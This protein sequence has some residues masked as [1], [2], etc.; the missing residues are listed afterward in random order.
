[1]LGHFQTATYTPAFSKSFYDTIGQL[2]ALPIEP[3][4]REICVLLSAAHF[5]SKYPAYVRAPMVKQF[6]TLTTEQTRALMAGER[7]VDLKK[8]EE[9]TFDILQELQVTRGP[10]SDE[11]F[12][13]AVHLLGKE[14]TLSVIYFAGLYSMISILANGADVGLPYGEDEV[15]V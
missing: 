1:L 11:T 4:V 6:T 15:T 10:L 13:E 8:N 2:Y 3:N 14:Q 7:P 12:N 9:I 5:K